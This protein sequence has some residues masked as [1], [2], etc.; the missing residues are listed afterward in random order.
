MR[1]RGPWLALVLVI[2][3]TLAPRPALAEWTSAPPLL[4]APTTPLLLRPPP[5]FFIGNL[6]TNRAGLITLA[7]VLGVFVTAAVIAV[8]IAVTTPSHA[9][10]STGTLGEARVRF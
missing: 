6:P 5:A 7:V 3:A 8:P 2:G 1:T 10:E 4:L 9:G